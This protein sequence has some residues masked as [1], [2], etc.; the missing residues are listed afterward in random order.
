MFK[1]N[2]MIKAVILY[3][4]AFI[5]PI[6]AFCQSDSTFLV[7]FLSS[8][9]V[10]LN[11]NSNS[12]APV[13]NQDKGRT[14]IVL[15]DTT[16]ESTLGEMEKLISTF[17]FS[18][19]Y[20]ILANKDSS[21]SY[22]RMDNSEIIPN[23]KEPED[24][25]NI[26]VSVSMPDTNFYKDGRWIIQRGTSTKIPEPVTLEVLET[27]EKKVILG[28]LCTKFVA[29]DSTGNP[30]IFIWASDRLPNTLLPFTGLTGFKYGI[31]EID[32]KSKGWHTKA[33]RIRILK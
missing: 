8:Q 28:Y 7:T 3:Y 2:F 1:L 4:I 25:S 19:T 16:Y 27:K 26:S 23:E 10:D 30:S 13:G 33:T 21:K 6:G 9:T 5:Y 14:V 22:F 11:Q 32:H 12:T 24:N 18:T 20:W 31:L 15:G 29:K 17:N